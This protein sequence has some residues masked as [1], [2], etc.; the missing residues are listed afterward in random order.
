M[1]MKKAAWEKHAVDQNIDLVKDPNNPQDSIATAARFLKAN[2]AH[3][4]PEGVRRALQAYSPDPAFVNDVLT[5]AYQYLTNTGE[6]APADACR[7]D[8]AGGARAMVEQAAV[9][10]I[11][12]TGGKAIVV[13]DYRPGD[14]LNHGGNN[15]DRAARDIA[16]PGVNALTGPWNS[17]LDTAA[18]AVAETFGQRYQPTGG[19]IE[20]F[21][22]KGFRCDLLYRTPANGGHLGHV[23]IGCHRK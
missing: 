12:A 19:V 15:S 16:M 8:A 13:S 11:F 7:A 6:A 3:D 5:W 2:G 21:D 1:G 18:K 14:A 20:G 4:G 17:D 9:R 23:H 22:Y 10:A